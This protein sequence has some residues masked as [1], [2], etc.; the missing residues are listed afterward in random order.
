MRALKKAGYR[1]CTGVAVIV[2][3]LAGCDKKPQPT[4]SLWSACL[5]KNVE[6]VRDMLTRDPSLARARTA[7]GSTPLH[8]A[9]ECASGEQIVRLLLGAGADA[10]AVRRDGETPLDIAVDRGRYWEAKVLLEQGARMSPA[11]LAR[12]VH[13]GLLTGNPALVHLAAGYG[14][15]APSPAMNAGFGRLEELEQQLGSDP[16]LVNRSQF[17]ASLLCYAVANRQRDVVRFLLKHGADVEVQGPCGGAL[18]YAVIA[19]DGTI[20]EL[21]LKA[22]ADVNA[23]SG[24]LGRTPLHWAAASGTPIVVELTEGGTVWRPGCGPGGSG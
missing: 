5:Q 20:V 1:W 21:L 19:Q 16:G 3:L 22:G 23:R 2:G 24:T 7:D 13:N 6:S 9:V 10:D 11:H 4:Q 12:A 17:G 15:A 18:S 14:Y 8:D